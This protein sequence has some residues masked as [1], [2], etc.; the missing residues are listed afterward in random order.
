MSAQPDHHITSLRT[1]L[2]VGVALL[3]LTAITVAVSFVSLGGWNAVVAVSI[4]TIKA[5]LVA[6]VFMHLL[7]D[8]KILFFVFLAGLLFLS[9]LITFTMFDVLR[10]DE[11]SPV[12]SRTVYKDVAIHKEPVGGSIG[13]DGASDGGGRGLSADL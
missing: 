10:R 9:V 5:L 6:L 1:Y 2:V 7:Y 11:I 3:S 4:A 8:K 13:I 12:S